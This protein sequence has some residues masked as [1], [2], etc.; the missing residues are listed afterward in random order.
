MYE[1][2]LILSILYIL[3]ILC[4]CVCVFVI[5]VVH[6]FA[7]DGGG[8]PVQDEHPASEDEQAMPTKHNS[9]VGSQVIMSAS[10]FIVEVC[11]F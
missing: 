10:L 6:V 1:Y 8:T 9:E 4:V 3:Y 11:I 5:D 7:D 2:T